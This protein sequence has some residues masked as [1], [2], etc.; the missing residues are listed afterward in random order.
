MLPAL[1]D[2]S[3]VLRKFPLKG[4]IQAICRF[5]LPLLMPSP[6]PGLG[7]ASLWCC[8]KLG[9]I[10]VLFCLGKPL[11]PALPLT[12]LAGPSPV[13]LSSSQLWSP[14]GLWVLYLFSGLCHLEFLLQRFEWY[15]QL[16]PVLERAQTPR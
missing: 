13:P 5:S 7:D 10:L 3:L 4:F 8:W 15:L 12:L 6:P 2:Q 16:V 1:A 11:L 9:R 14:L